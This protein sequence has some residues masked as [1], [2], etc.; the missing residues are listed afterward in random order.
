MSATGQDAHTAPSETALSDSDLVA[1]L[2][3]TSD[4]APGSVWWRTRGD[5]FGTG[6][7][8]VYVP[9]SDLFTWGCADVEEIAAHDVHTLLDTVE[10]TRSVLVSAGVSAWVE[11]DALLLWVARKRGTRPQG[12]AYAV[13]HPALWDLFDLAGP[14]RK[15]DTFNPRPR[16]TAKQEVRLESR[17]SG[18][19]AELRAACT[20]ADDPRRDD[21]TL[22]VA[23]VRRALTRASFD[24]C[25][26]LTWT[27]GTD[28][29]LRLYAVAYDVPG[30]D[31][32]TAAAITDATIGSFENSYAVIEAA[33]GPNS[34]HERA[35][36]SYVAA[37][38]GLPAPDLDAT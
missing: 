28:G 10:E 34:A 8:A 25:D 4:L 36:A 33:E 35:V 7:L 37:Q 3:V 22:D 16:P 32:V 38:R 12:A 13:L 26:D 14:E 20:A 11:A 19:F 17:A 30:W 6:D 29:A 31:E 9:C 1:L 15:T 27:A 23:T 21:A 2:A 24:Y 18:E 5:T